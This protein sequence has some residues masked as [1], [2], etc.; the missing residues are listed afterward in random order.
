MNPAATNFVVTFP[1]GM[2]GRKD[3]MTS[4]VAMKGPVKKG[5][6]TTDGS[7]MMAESAFPVSGPMAFR[8]S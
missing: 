3:A 2:T 8:T 6:A 5:F 7:K 4:P 1:G